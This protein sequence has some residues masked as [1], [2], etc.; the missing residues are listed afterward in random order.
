MN[1]NIYKLL[2]SRLISATGDQFY[3]IA[4]SVTLYKRTN[5]ILIATS[6]PMIK[7]LISLYGIFFYKKIEVI[8]E[9]KIAIIIDLIR[10]PLMFLIVFLLN[11]KLYSVYI[12]VVFL[13]ILQLYYS[14]TRIVLLN[15]NI[16]NEDKSKI[17]TY[18]QILT[19]VAMA[20]GTLFGGV[21]TYRIGYQWSIIFNGISFLISALLLMAIPNSVSELEKNNNISKCGI[22]G[23]LYNTEYQ[24][25]VKIRVLIGALFYGPV[26]AFNALIMLFVLVK[27]KLTPEHYGFIEASMSV[28]LFIGSFLSIKIKRELNEAFLYI[29]PFFMA[30]CYIFSASIAIYFISIILLF[31]SAIFNMIYS[32]SIRNSIVNDFKST[33]LGIVWII[34]RGLISI[35]GALFT[36]VISYIGKMSSIENA[37]IISGIMVLSISLLFYM[38]SK[39][40]KST[41]GGNI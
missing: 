8:S 17:N 25:L 36:L 39:K 37:Q 22:I 40:V 33:D 9:K 41:I 7:G 1:K 4:I 11:Y 15:N 10:T 29:A 24:L 23:W 34:Y 18:D 3:N 19:T 16:I 35:L 12:I 30:I 32:C 38:H 21:L 20:F 6:I 27:L 31:I 5:S 26:M 2:I 14:P 28:G 13:E